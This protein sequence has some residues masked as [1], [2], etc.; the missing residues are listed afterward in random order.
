MPE[1]YAMTTFAPTTCAY[2]LC[3]ARPDGS[4]RQY[5]SIQRNLERFLVWFGVGSGIRFLVGFV[6]LGT[7]ESV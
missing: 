7:C 5:D 3:L 6:L 4:Q 1:T 2:W